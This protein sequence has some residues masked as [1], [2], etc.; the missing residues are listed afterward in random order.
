MSIPLPIEPTKFLT[1]TILMAYAVW[2][3]FKRSSFSTIHS[4]LVDSYLSNGYIVLPNTRAGT[5]SIQL[6]KMAIESK[7]GQGIFFASLPVSGLRETRIAPKAFRT[8]LL[9][10]NFSL[11]IINLVMGTGIAR[12][13]GLLANH[14]NLTPFLAYHDIW[15]DGLKQDAFANPTETRLFHRD[16]LIGNAKQMCK[17]FVLFDPID[18]ET[19]PFQIV[20]GSHYSSPGS[21]MQL[22]EV[23]DR[24]EGR[25]SESSVISVYGNSSLS[26]HDGTNGLVAAA[27][28]HQCLHRGLMQSHGKVRVMLALYFIFK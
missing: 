6:V 2:L 3:K 20:K 13:I 19:G 23:P 1:S 18:L 22:E 7:F 11:G 12:F 14:F 9:H 16:G 21:R 4:S 17:I 26:V 27:D 8:S 25:Y 15:I 10:P 5:R 28:T 24:L